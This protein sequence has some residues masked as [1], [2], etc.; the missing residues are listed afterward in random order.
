MDTLKMDVLILKQT[1][2][3]VDWHSIFHSKILFL[4]EK[5]QEFRTSFSQGK[6][7]GSARVLG[8][9]S[10]WQDGAAKSGFTV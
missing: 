1:K 9:C 10:S 7:F 8:R 4:G 6:F 3:G 2:L 5:R